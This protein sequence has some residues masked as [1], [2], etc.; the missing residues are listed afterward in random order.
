MEITVRQVSWVT[1]QREGA[2]ESEQ[3]RF[4]KYQYGVEREIKTLDSE[5]ERLYNEQDIMD[6]ELE[7]LD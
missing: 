5:K 3:K 1:G 7:M 6:T 2:M 4:Y